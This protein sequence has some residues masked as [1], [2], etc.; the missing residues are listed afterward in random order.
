MGRYVATYRG[1][2]TETDLYGTRERHADRPSGEVRGSEGSECGCQHTLAS[3]GEM[4][5]QFRVYSTTRNEK[6]YA[7]TN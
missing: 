5:K 3:M 2:S 6:L 1:T 4:R 7:N